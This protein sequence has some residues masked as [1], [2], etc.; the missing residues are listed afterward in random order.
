MSNGLSLAVCLA[1]NSSFWFDFGKVVLKVE[2]HQGIEGVGT[3]PYKPD[4]SDGLTSS[5]TT[6]DGLQKSYIST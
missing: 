5:T 1:V 4:K 2:R 3:D 6:R